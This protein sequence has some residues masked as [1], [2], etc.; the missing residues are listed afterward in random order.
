MGADFVI[1]GR[2]PVHNPFA[3]L[4]TR[5]DR[6]MTSNTTETITCSST[7]DFLRVLPQLTG[8][9]DTNCLFIVFFSGKRAKRS[10]RLD[11]PESFGGAVERSYV[12][13]LS[14]MIRDLSGRFEA[15]SE[16]VLVISTTA[17]FADSGGAPH[18]GFAKRLHR[19]LMRD[20]VRLR[21][22][23]VL[24]ADGWGEYDDP[25][26]PRAGRPLSAIAPHDDEHALGHGV[27]ADAGAD[28]SAASGASSP[29]S[30]SGTPKP[31]RLRDMGEIPSPNESQVALVASVG[32]ELTELP[33]AGA[34]RGS[35]PE[36]G[37]RMR[38]VCAV[39]RALL[40]FDTPMQPR[41]IARLLRLTA[42]SDLW[43]A[44]ALALLTRPEAPE[45]I[46]RGGGH[47]SF[48]RVPLGSQNEPH[49][50]D[51][52]R[53]TVFAVLASFSP[54]CAHPHKFVSLRKR[55]AEVLTS[56][57]E[58]NRPRVLALSSWIWWTSGLQSIALQHISEALR[59][60]AE[61]AVSHMVRELVEVPLFGRQS[62]VSVEA[63]ESD[64]RAA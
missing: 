3:V 24:A 19:C 37:R 6:C 30:T 35:V 51:N 22:F 4:H 50:V 18:R 28:G 7:A 15:T 53:W 61:H 41:M 56:V 31:P 16:P 2:V 62:Y 64:C 63:E 17:S 48:D 46:V 23:C 42:D 32:R 11:L 8:F 26:L 14:D 55:M 38:E 49:D 29:V 13:G 34:L 47:T 12:E 1:F 58:A 43:F 33:P 21:D 44:L 9:T 54:E 36:A 5:N 10:A 39:A 45:E 57:N 20:G 40:Q 25:Q 60:T 52:H 59:I 27:G